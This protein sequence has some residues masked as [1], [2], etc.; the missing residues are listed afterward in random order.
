MF[1]E[2]GDG[3]QVKSEFLNLGS[4][5]FFIISLN[6]YWLCF[7]TWNLGAGRI[8]FCVDFMLFRVERESERK[9]DWIVW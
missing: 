3:F 8:F 5:Y 2:L 9:R 7:E 6:S 1:I 4:C